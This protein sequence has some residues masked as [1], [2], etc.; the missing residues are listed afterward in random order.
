M[1]DRTGKLA[2]HA[3]GLLVTATGQAAVAPAEELPA[4]RMRFLARNPNMRQFLASE[5][6]AIFKIRVGCFEVVEGYG[7][8]R[9]WDLVT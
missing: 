1:D 2:D 5:A 8:P 7:R 9:L 6:V 3:D 4:A